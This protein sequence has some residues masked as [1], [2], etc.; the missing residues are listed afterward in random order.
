MTGNWVSGVT[1]AAHDLIPFVRP[2]TYAYKYRREIQ[3]YWIKLLLS[4]NKG[5]P[6]I[7][8]TGT[9]GAG[10]SVLMSHYHGEANQL[11]W[12]VPGSSQ[13]TEVK[14]I[15]IGE[16]TKIVHV[17]PG[18]DGFEKTSALDVGFGRTSGLNGV[19]HVVDWGYTAIRDSAV[20]AQLVAT[21]N[22]VT[23]DDLRKKSLEAELLE[24][25]HVCDNIRRSAA[26]G[27]G[28]K[29]FVIAV[30]K[31]DLYVAQ[32]N[33]AR[34]YYGLDDQSKFRKILI[35]LL[36]DIGRHNLKCIVLPVCSM[37]TSFEWN[38]QIRKPQLDS[39]EEQRAFMRSFVDEIGRISQ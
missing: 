34:D 31:V 32:L 27:R 9:S 30:N 6:D 4:L 29:W 36:I 7:L 38:G 37:P 16:W 11:S 24:F 15:A 25:K 1:D 19:I 13:D 17:L 21:Q 3:S 22:V 28:P 5:S 2:V 39:V 8:V 26:A 33:D 12:Q 18:Q 14:P 20:R 35:G 10:K 23:I